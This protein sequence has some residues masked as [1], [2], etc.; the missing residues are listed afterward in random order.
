MKTVA[1]FAALL[2]TLIGGPNCFLASANVQS[3]AFTAAPP[4]DI[5]T[6]DTITIGADFDYPT[7]GTLKVQL[8]CST[9]DGWQN[10]TQASTQISAGN[11]QQKNLSVN[12][13]AGTTPGGGYLWMVQVHNA[14]G[15][16]KVEKFQY[17]VNLTA[18]PAVT[19]AQP[20]PTSVGA[21]G[22]Y[23]IAT[24]VDYPTA[25]TLK[26]I[27]F[28][29]DSGWSNVAQKSIAINSGNGQQFDLNVAIPSDAAAGDGHVWMIQVHDPNGAVK[30]EQ[31]VYNVTVGG[32]TPPPPQPPGNA[33]QFLPP[34]SSGSWNPVPDWADEFT[35][36]G[37][38]GTNEPANWFAHMGTG[39]W[40]YDTTNEK[41]LRW[42]G[43]TPDSAWMFSTKFA[44]TL[45]DG[46]G[47]Y[48][49]DGS[50]EGHLVLRAAVDKRDTLN[51]ASFGNA[52]PKVECAYLQTGRPVNP[53][54]V[55]G[56]PLPTYQGDNASYTLDP[57][58]G[59]FVEPG[60]KGIYLSCRA[61]MNK[62]G[63]STWFAFWAHTH[64]Q[65]YENKTVNAIN[66][67]NQSV[68]NSSTGTEIDIVEIWGSKQAYVL[69]AFSNNNH[70]K[71]GFGAN[72]GSVG[73]RYDNG[74]TNTTEPLAPT[75][76]TVE[77]GNWHE[78]GV[79]WMPNELVYYVD[80]QETFRTQSNVPSNP[81]DMMILLTLE[82][83]VDKWEGNQGDGRTTTD[84]NGYIS[85]NSTLRVLSEVEVDWVR[86][87]KMQ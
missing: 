3:V 32:G 57:W 69:N 30:K 10:I 84:T 17:N 87:H 14:S 60:P 75:G 9:G 77:D 59:K 52:G 45:S 74:G 78:F 29:T 82:F 49:L 25:G 34:L 63:H 1:L 50:A 46:K 71:D 12:V 62:L 26:A 13:P 47:T 68:F 37:I 21:G 23:P 41:G 54:S 16:N 36:N 76:L 48:Y 73:V 11:N 43:S 39:W 53:N 2:L 15:G 51:N 67:P 35:G 19:F 38:N 66:N 70:W 64:T 81:R 65:A 20:P 79:H 31:F 56:Y 5:A 86:V 27:L 33:G 6:G 80:G 7:A 4:T 24:I 83:Q 8:F 28:N 55:S 40:S 58:A 44:N 18:G 61:K 72:A 22:T 42:S 85:D